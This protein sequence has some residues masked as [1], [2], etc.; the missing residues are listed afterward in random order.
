MRLRPVDATCSFPTFETAILPEG[1]E[2][3]SN[4]LEKEGGGTEVDKME[5]GKRQ[6]RRT[7]MDQ[8]NE[9]GEGKGRKG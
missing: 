3:K 4:P 8:S 6:G 2:S 9:I 1:R 7:R 5:G